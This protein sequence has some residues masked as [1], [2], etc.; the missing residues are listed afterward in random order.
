MELYA[1]HPAMPATLQ[2]HGQINM[3]AQG[4]KT[5]VVEALDG[6][7]V[8]SNRS[9]GQVLIAAPGRLSCHPLDQRLPDPLPS[10]NVR[11]DDRFHLTAGAVIQQSGQSDDITVDDG[12][13]R[14]HSL[15]D[16]EVF[17]KPR[18]RIVSADAWISVELSVVVDQ[19]RP[20]TPAGVIVVRGVLA[21]SHIHVHRRYPHCSKSAS[22]NKALL[23]E[24]R[25][26]DH[27]PYG[28]S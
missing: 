22:Q 11:H 6:G 28:E 24:H 27:P 21:Y 13:P 2:I 14:I 25:R 10:P 17:V 5:R 16:L 7:D 3:A 4:P 20:Q 12:H 26:D 15:R 18:A 8:A 9:N 1:L 19:L 23:I